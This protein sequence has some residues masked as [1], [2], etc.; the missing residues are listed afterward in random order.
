MREE[1]ERKGEHAISLVLRYGALISTIVMAVGVILSLFRKP[2]APFVSYH[3]IHPEVLFAGIARLDPLAI[4]ELGVLLLL[5]TP[6]ARIV[7]AVITFALER[8][9]KYVLI[10]L[11]VL[12]VVLLSISFAV[13]G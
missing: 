3:S 7:V 8:E 6:L 12:A 1:T 5:L 11:G 4:T 2:A 9:L 13:E 10:S